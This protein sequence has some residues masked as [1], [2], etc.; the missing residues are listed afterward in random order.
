M[1]IGKCKS[2]TMN[3]TMDWIFKYLLRTGVSTT[4]SPEQSSPECSIHAWK[5]N[6]KVI[7]GEGGED[8]SENAVGRA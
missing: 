5:N 6:L 8:E 4:T 7:L 3:W 2:W 1:K